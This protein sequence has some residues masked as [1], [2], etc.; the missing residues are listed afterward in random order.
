[1]KRKWAWLVGSV[2]LLVAID[3]ITKQLAHAFLRDRGITELVPGVIELFYRRN[4]G[5]FRSLGAELDPDVR[6]VVFVGAS[7]AASLLIIRLYANAE[8]VLRWALVCLLGGA[9]GNLIDRVI[10]GEVID[11]LHVSWW[12]T[13]NVADILIS[14]GIALLVVDLLRGKPALESAS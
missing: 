13:F 2:A 3:Q 8:G 9:I 10:Y 1:M 5:A 12:A 4:P 11:F 14:A 6:R 7:A